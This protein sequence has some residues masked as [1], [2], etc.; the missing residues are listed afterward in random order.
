MQEIFSTLPRHTDVRFTY[1][2]LE[3]VYHAHEDLRTLDR[4]NTA[5]D[6]KIILDLSSYDAFTSVLK[7]VRL[8]EYVIGS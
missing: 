6:K 8:T 3:D 1:R 2:K 4:M 7:Q 5:D